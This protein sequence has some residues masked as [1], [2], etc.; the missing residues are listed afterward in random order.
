MLFGEDRGSI[1]GG[2]ETVDGGQ[3][4][5]VGGDGWERR[6][7]GREGGEEEEGEGG[8]EGGLERQ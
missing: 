4:G 7:G 2:V 3:G 5:R 6:K 8:R 1:E